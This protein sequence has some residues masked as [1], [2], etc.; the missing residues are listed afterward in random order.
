MDYSVGQPGW[1]ARK[2][3]TPPLVPQQLGHPTLSS[4]EG[5]VLLGSMLERP[6]SNVMCPYMHAHLHPHTHLH[7]PMHMHTHTHTHTHTHM[8]AHTHTEKFDFQTT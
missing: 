8:H 1:L 3:I 6:R 5:A 4:T 7:P 2:W